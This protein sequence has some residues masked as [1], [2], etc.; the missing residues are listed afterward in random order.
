MSRIRKNMTIC[1]LFSRVNKSH[2][3]L[4][5][6]FVASLLIRLWLLDKRWINVDEGAHLMDGVLALD[7]KIPRVDFASRSPIYVYAIAGFLKL[8]GTNYISGRLLSVTCSLLTGMVVF[9]IAR[10]LFDRKVAL[11][12]AVMYWMLPLELSQ[13]AIVKTEPLAV[14]LTCLALYA[15]VRFSVRSQKPW[16]ILAGV[17]AALTFYVRE[18]ALIIPV[19]VFGFMVLFHGGRVREAAKNLALFLAGYTAVIL[20]VLGY[21]SRFVSPG[22]LLTSGLNPFGYLT[23]AVQRL[24]SLCGLSSGSTDFFL[25]QASTVSWHHYYEYL[26]QAFYLHSFLLIA[27]GFSVVEFG[28]RVLTLSKQK[29]REYVVSHAVLYLW[30]LFLFIGYALQFYTRGFFIDYSREFLPPL[31]IIFSAWFRYSVSALERNGVVERIILGG[32]ALCALLFFMQANYRDFFGIGHHSSLVIGLITLL[33]FAAAFESSTRRFVFMSILLGIVAFIAVSRQAPLKAHFSGT[34]PSL[35]MIGTI[36]GLT[37]A[38][39]GEKARPSLAGYVKFVSLSIVVASFVVSVSFSAILLDLSYDSTWSPQAVEKIASHLKAETS[40][41]DEVMSGAVIWE[42]QASRRPFQMISHPLGFE[43]GIAEAKKA[44]IELGA[45][46]RPPRAIIL[47]GFTEKIYIRHVP[48]L[49]ELLSSRYQFV[50]ATGPPG[51]PVRLYRL[52]DQ[53]FIDIAQ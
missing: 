22:N 11:L 47:D 33:T 24:L 16:L 36:Y 9:L 1:Q 7:G 45:A 13:S 51:P 44:T 41:A 18:S 48:W 27:L 14:L 25:S 4:L 31:V 19:T 37:W 40:D 46:T 28:Y 43:Y 8:F 26:D 39:L 10:A 42:V 30:I 6:V 15:V 34:V 12:S 52:N 32:L 49:N 3:I 2:L 38:L 50:T 29:S 21:Y 53:P 35:V 23:W 17:F 20:L 5:G